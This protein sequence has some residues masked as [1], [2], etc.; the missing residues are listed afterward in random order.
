MT[1]MGAWLV[2]EPDCRMDGHIERRSAG[3][4]QADV[5]GGL[6]G[7]GRIRP[8]GKARPVRPFDFKGHIGDGARRDLQRGGEGD[9]DRRAG[10]PQIHVRPEFL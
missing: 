10:R 4:Q 3:G 7:R 8:D 2:Q 5:I 9:I 6:I 1:R